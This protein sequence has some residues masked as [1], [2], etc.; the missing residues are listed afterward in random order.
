[1][2]RNMAIHLTQD[3]L[4]TFQR[5]GFVIVR[6]VFSQDE[7]AGIRAGAYA[8]A[9]A[10]GM[11]PG[12]GKG[13]ALPGDVGSHALLCHLIT[14]PRVV[15]VARQLLDDQ[16][17]HFR[18]SAVGVGSL[19][20]GWHKDNRTADRYDLSGQDWDGD[21][22]LIRMGIYC[23]DHVEHSGGLALRVGSHTPEE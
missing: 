12:T 16:P 8:E 21:Y 4:A 14:D 22:P 19:E 10:A 23:Q 7:I 17:V 3:Q 13:F 5:D 15:A 9:A 1:M 18:D 11:R 20:R 2:P 6:G